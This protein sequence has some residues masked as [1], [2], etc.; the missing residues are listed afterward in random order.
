MSACSPYANISNSD[1]EQ[2]EI[3]DSGKYYR[4]YKLNT[5]QTG[6]DIY[7]ADGAIVLS[8]KNRPTS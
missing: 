1:S 3:I 7:N 2:K 5:N 4:I 8:E 6:Y